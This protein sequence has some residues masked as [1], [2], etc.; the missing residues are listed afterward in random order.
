MRKQLW[1]VASFIGIAVVVS[2]SLYP[3]GRKAAQTEMPAATAFRI[4]LGVGDNAPAAWDG[5]IAAG[6]GKILDIRGWR[7]AAGDSTDSVSSWKAST[8][9]SPGRKGIPGP[10]LENGVIVTATDDAAS[11]NV[12]TAQGSFS[13]RAQEVPFGEQKN[14]LNGKAIGGARARPR[15]S[16]P[17]LPKSRTI[18]PSPRAATR[19]TSATWSSCTATGRRKSKG[20]DQAPK[21]F[22]FLARPA[23]GDQ[24]FLLRIPSRSAPGARRCRSRRPSRT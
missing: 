3:Q 4:L 21:N 7:F 15:C 1:I 9:L 8:R 2:V 14:F 13:F 5:S 22:D 10:I 12:K 17:V 23:G 6:S 20:F 16:S 18:P 24:V 11:F 19:S